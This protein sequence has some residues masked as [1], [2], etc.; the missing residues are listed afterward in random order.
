M[1]KK[2]KQTATLF[3]LFPAHVTPSVL[4]TGGHALFLPKVNYLTIP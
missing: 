2:H 3:F 1:G 4:N